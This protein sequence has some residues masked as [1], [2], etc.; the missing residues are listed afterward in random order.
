MNI[1]KTNTELKYAREELSKALSDLQD[2]FCL[3]ERLE[4]TLKSLSDG[5]DAID[6]A[7]DEE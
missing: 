6:L 7:I 3:A 5:I 2:I 1:I 4:E